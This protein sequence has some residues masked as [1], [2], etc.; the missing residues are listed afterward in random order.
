[1]IN[2][3]KSYSVHLVILSPFSPLKFYQFQFSPFS[4][5][6]SNSVHSIYIGQILST[7]A[8]FCPL[9]SSSVYFVYLSPIWS[10]SVLFSPFVH[11]G[12]IQSTSVQSVYFDPILI[13]S[14]SVHS[15]LFYLFGPLCSI[16][17]NSVHSD[18]FGS[19]WSNSIYFSALT[20]WEKTCL[21]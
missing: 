12:P 16:W 19:F 18:H 17:S 11:S 9:R 15:V 6:Q 10:I 2:I 21:G 7:F 14:Y 8:L 20:I 5:I 13:R 1:M 4:L 3:Q